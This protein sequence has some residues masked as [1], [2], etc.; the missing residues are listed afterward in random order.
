MILPK[1]LLVF[2]DI[3]YSIGRMSTL[4][5]V[6]A[7]EKPDNVALL[8]DNIEL[9]L[10]NDAKKAYEEFFP[11]FNKL[12][13]IR[14]TIVMLGDNDYQY[15]HNKDLVKIVESYSPINFGMNNM[16][17]FKK[18]K[19]NFFH[20]NLEKSEII[21]KLGHYAVRHLNKIDYR[22]VP[23]LLSSLVRL[24]FL[25]PS[26]EYLLLG[27]LHFLGLIKRTVFCGTLNYKSTPFPRSIGYVT[28]MHDKFVPVPNGIK[29][30]RIGKGPVHK[31]YS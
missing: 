14:K 5:E 29:I 16:I 23:S 11:A 1:K 19:I 12:F 10:F 7:T 24:N 26:S 15:A 3:H 20:G 13:P 25:I 22:I 18:G 2:S 8:G 21:E 31:D 17:F 4:R 28:I 30:H 9:S 6:I 27:H